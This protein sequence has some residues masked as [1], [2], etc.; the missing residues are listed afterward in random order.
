MP[1]RSLFNINPLRSTR[2]KRKTLGPGPRVPWYALVSLGFQR[3]LPFPKSIPIS[4]SGEN[5]NGESSKGTIRCSATAVLHGLTIM[6]Q[7]PFNRPSECLGRKTKQ[8]STVHYMYYIYIYVC[9][10]WAPSSKT[11]IQ[12]IRHPQTLPYTCK[13]TSASSSPVCHPS[14]LVCSPRHFL[15]GH[16]DGVLLLLLSLPAH[17]RHLLE[18][19]LN[20]TGAVKRSS[21]CNLL[22]GYDVNLQNIYMGYL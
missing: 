9:V 10:H 8:I 16:A 2:N 4:S 3:P 13:E 17:E 18:R 12:A 7:L 19:S 15:R 1:R 5:G 22:G 21:I 6:F 20:F 14:I 11:V